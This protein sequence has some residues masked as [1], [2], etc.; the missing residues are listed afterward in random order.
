MQI[1]C[2][3]NAKLIQSILLSL[4]SNVVQFNL[5]IFYLPNGQISIFYQFH[6]I[7]KKNIT[8]ILEANP[9]HLTMFFLI[10]WSSQ[11]M[12]NIFLRTLFSAFKYLDNLT[13]KF[14]VLY[15][16]RSNSL[17]QKILLKIH[18]IID[19]TNFHITTICK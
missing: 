4:N 10:H 12:H 1:C 2:K 6:A 16:L 11:S 13:Y 3:L 7:N 5:S 8:N 15:F 19:C 9:R 18:I 14:I 17:F